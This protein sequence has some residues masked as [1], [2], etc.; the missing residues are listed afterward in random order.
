MWGEAG[1]GRNR[2]PGGGMLEVLEDTPETSRQK[3]CRQRKARDAGRVGMKE[4]AD[5]RRFRGQTMDIVFFI[6]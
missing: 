2:G 1:E 3:G 6:L 5:C 4:K